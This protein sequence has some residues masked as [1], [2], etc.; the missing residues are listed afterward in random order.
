VPAPDQGVDNGVGG[1]GSDSGNDVR[2][3]TIT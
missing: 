1:Q 2:Q 3:D